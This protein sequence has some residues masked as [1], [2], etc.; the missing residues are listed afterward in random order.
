MKKGNTT[1]SRVGSPSFSGSGESQFLG[2]SLRLFGGYESFLARW[3]LQLWG[4]FVFLRILLI[5]STVWVWSNLKFSLNFLI[6]LCFIQTFF[7]LGLGIGKRKL[8]L[9]K[10]WT[11][12]LL[13]DGL[14]LWRLRRVGFQ[15]NRLTFTN[16]NWFRYWWFWTLFL[17]AKFMSLQRSPFFLFTNL[18]F[19]LGQTLI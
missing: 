11:T 14:K 13:F 5:T 16:L 17:R 15:F 8:R 10:G 6:I 19:L 2:E 18:N 9:V 3:R 4:N 12:S 7:N 1:L